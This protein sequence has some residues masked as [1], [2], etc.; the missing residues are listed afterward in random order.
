MATSTNIQYLVNSAKDEF[1]ATVSIKTASDRRQ[2][3][4]FIAGAAITAG[5]WVQFDTSA[6][7]A[8]R[9]LTVIQ[10][11]AGFAAGN[12]LVCGVA[13]TAATVA[14]QTV[15]VVVAGYAE[16][17][18]VAAAVAAAGVALVV[19]NTAAG[20]AVAIAAADTAPACG[21]SLEAAGVGNTCDVWVIKQF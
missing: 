16:L 17:A 10:A 14:G 8:G 21:V 7:D 19:D 20:R 4:T 15:D 18:N 13:L 1:G 3:E 6:T 11:G 5:D 2:I 9:V 12:P